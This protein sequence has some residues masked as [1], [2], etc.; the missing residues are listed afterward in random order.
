MM[1]YVIETG[2]ARIRF[3]GT[4]EAVNGKVWS[5]MREKNDAVTVYDESGAEVTSV[6]PRW[7]I[8]GDDI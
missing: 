3:T 6:S 2:G 5:M 8:G 1:N 7:D 4:E